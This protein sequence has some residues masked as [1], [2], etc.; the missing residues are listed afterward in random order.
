MSSIQRQCYIENCNR[1]HHASGY[2][3]MHYSR[4]WKYGDP[5]IV[6]KPER[7]KIHGMAKSPE[8]KVWSL[9]KQRCYNESAGNYSLYGGRGI[10]ICQRWLDS[11]ANFY[12]DMGPRPNSD[13]QIDRIN[14]DGNY[15]PSNCR[16]ATRHQQA[17]NRRDLSNPQSGYRGVYRSQNKWRAR[18]KVKCK[19]IDLGTFDT[20]KEASIAYEK[21]RKEVIY[22]GNIEAAL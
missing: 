8:F 9:M 21:K 17:F 14:N 13:Y 12:E 4:F 15:E 10:K 2:C 1:R 19:N 7:K 16:W 5:E 22:L 3:S 20:A 6:L 11:F 18:I